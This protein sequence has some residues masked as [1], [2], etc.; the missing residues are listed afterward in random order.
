M[1]NLMD[2]KELRLC[3]GKNTEIKEIVVEITLDQVR[4]MHFSLSVFCF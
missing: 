4:K 1:V 3:A 2:P